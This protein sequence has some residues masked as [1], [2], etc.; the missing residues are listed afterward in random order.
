[1]EKIE[2]IVKQKTREKGAR[3]IEKHAEYMEESL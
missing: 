2:G 1:V 3:I